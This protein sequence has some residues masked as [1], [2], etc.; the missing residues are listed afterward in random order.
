MLLMTECENVYLDASKLA[1]N[2]LKRHGDANAR[3]VKWCK[4]R[5]PLHNYLR[6]APIMHE[7]RAIK[8]I[9]EVDLLQKACN[10]TEKGFR[11]LLKFVKPGV[12]EYEIEAE[13]VHEFIRN[14]SRGFAYGPIIASGQNAC[15]LHYTDN[16]KACKAGDVLLLD[17]AAEYANYNSDFNQKH[18]C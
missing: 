13:L 12:M 18:S 10:I 1:E 6:C 3:F 8:S 2:V 4:D 11:R 9:M 15:V 14:R 16:D 5:Y 17:V 7:L